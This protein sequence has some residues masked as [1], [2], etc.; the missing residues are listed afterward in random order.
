MKKCEIWGSQSGVA[1]EPSLLGCND[2][3]T[4]K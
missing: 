2:N 4:V 3:S 1:E